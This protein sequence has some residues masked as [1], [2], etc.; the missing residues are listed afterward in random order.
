VHLQGLFIL[1]RHGMAAWMNAWATTA[2]TERPEA[3]TERVPLP[4]DAQREVVDVL[5][6]MTVTLTLE[7]RT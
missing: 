4:L 7:R 3:V 6:A 5:A 2:R 1:M